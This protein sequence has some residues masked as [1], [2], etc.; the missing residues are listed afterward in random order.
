ME[1][2][3]MNLNDA[4]GAHRLRPLDWPQQGPLFFTL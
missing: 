2:N 4:H 3:I 1:T